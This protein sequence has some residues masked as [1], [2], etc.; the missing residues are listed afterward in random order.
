MSTYDYNKNIARLAN[1]RL[2]IVQIPGAIFHIKKVNLPGLSI[3]HMKTNTVMNSYNILGG[4]L[5]YGNLDIEFYVDEDFTNYTEIFDWL[6]AIAR[7]LNLNQRKE[8]IEKH[9]IGLK[10]DIRDHSALFSDGTLILLTNTLRVNKAFTLINL[11]PSSLSGMNFAKDDSGQDI[12]TANC[13]FAMDSF[14]FAERGSFS[15]A[16]P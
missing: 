2:N 7:P 13:S 6:A 16:R 1:W 4:E 8:W 15:E 5:D 10:G 14:E 9:K 11:A 3:Q 12:I